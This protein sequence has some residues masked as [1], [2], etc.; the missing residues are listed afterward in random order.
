MPVDSAAACDC[1]L[2]LGAPGSVATWLHTAHGYT[3]AHKRTAR[4]ASHPQ[5]STCTC[6]TRAA[7]PP[8]QGRRL[9]GRARRGKRGRSSRSGALCTRRRSGGVGRRRRESRVRARGTRMRRGT[10][11]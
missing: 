3:T 5:T 7:R 6:R 1:D 4:N 8:L 11:R 9:G 2:R 10:A